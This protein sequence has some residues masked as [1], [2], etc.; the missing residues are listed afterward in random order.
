MLSAVD[1][2]TEATR[3]QS[4]TAAQATN[5]S[6]EQHSTT[7]NSI[8]N[9]TESAERLG[10]TIDRAAEVTTDSNGSEDLPAEAINHRFT[11]KGRRR[12]NKDSMFTDGEGND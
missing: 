8:N 3:E 1:R 7:M 4:R 6:R 11:P 5:T 10:H 12:R 2:L 9:Q